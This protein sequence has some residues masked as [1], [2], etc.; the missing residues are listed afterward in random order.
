M[1]EAPPVARTGSH[2]PLTSYLWFEK[3]IIFQY[4]LSSKWSSVSLYALY[5]SFILL[6]IIRVWFDFL[7][8]TS[9]TADGLT[10]SVKSWLSWLSIFFWVT[11]VMRKL[12]LKKARYNLLKY[13][14]FRWFQAE[15]AKQHGTFVM[16]DKFPWAKTCVIQRNW[17]TS[18]ISFWR[19]LGH[20]WR[21]WWWRS[22]GRGMDDHLISMEPWQVPCHNCKKYTERDIDVSM[23]ESTWIWLWALRI[24]MDSVC[25]QYQRSLRLARRRRTMVVTCAP[26]NLLMHS[27]SVH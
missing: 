20:R 8:K 21:P 24:K 27:T 17:K 13:I 9:R 23:S 26:G 3:S 14:G 22:G 16:H 7:S 12:R 10:L 11:K 18:Q 1:T 19:S 5:S 15:V 4:C 25:H 6:Y 2:L